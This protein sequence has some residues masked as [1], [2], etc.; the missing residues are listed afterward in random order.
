MFVKLHRDEQ[1]V[2]LAACDEDLV[3]QTF[4]DGD[5]KLDVNEI[6]YR[7]EALDRNGLVQRMKSVD[8]MNLVGDE[9]VTVAIEEGYA[10]EEDVIVIAGVKHVQVVLL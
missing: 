7:G 1:A 9:T 6:F 3:G 2:I 10:S 5:R 4:R 8:I